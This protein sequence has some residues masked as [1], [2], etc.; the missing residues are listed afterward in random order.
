[1]RVGD[2]VSIGGIEGTVSRIRTRAT[3]VIDWDNKEVVIPN[4]TFIT[5]KLTN[6]TLSD[7]VTRVVIKLGVAY[8]SDPE[9]VRSML[10]ELARAHAK[11][12]KEPPPS[13][14]CVALASSTLDFELRIFVGSV[15]DRN[16]VRN[17]LHGA[18]LREC[19]ARGI[20]ISFPQTDVWLRNLPQPPP[21]AADTKDS[22]R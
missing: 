4:K 8:S 16:A 21:S 17:D 12:L 13:C 14:W 22:K 7:A 1:M 19:R 15:M 3:T 9:A 20:E 18:I 10:L 11:V 2:I 6:W 5:E